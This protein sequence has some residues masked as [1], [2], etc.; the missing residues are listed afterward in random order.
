MSPHSHGMLRS[1][2]VCPCPPGHGSHRGCISP[3]FS[4]EGEFTPQGH[5]QCLETSLI[6][7]AGHGERPLEPGL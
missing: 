6:V 3:G 4:A 7:T 1:F 2:R 5:W